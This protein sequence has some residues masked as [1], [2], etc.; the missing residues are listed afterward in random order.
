MSKETIE[1]KLAQLMDL[2]PE[3]EGLIAA[4]TD[5]NVIVGQTLTEMDH[6]S[7]AKACAKILS[8]SNTLGNDIGKG[9]VK[10]TTIELEGGYAVLA[11][12]EKLLLIA[13][14]GVD[15]RASL[16]LLKRNLISISNL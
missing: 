5:G 15:G 2:V 16:G 12:S 8:D 7:I 6:G 9:T 13:L 11:G 4:D 14:A 10:N 1:P 3:C